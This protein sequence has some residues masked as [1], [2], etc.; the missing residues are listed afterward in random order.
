MS[1]GVW[2]GWGRV[3]WGGVS[4]SGLLGPAQPSHFLPSL[5]VCA[6][7]FLLRNQ[8]P[9]HPLSSQALRNLSVTHSCFQH[10]PVS[11][12]SLCPCS[13]PSQ[14][15]PLQNLWPAPGCC[16]PSDPHCGPRAFPRSSHAQ[17]GAP[18]GG[19]RWLDALSLVSGTR[20]LTEN[21]FQL[22]ALYLI[23][24]PPPVFPVLGSPPC[25]RWHP[26]PWPGSSCPRRGPSPCQSLPGMC[27][28]GS[29]MFNKHLLC[30]STSRAQGDREG[31]WSRTWVR[32]LEPAPHSPRQ[33]NPSES[34]PWV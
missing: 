31:G 5:Q 25:A 10:I 34:V 21:Q 7:G 24:G 23:S 17:G 20:V 8:H 33:V 30:A 16:P 13:H 4:L 3:G 12:F 6:R 19:V 2:A 11:A 9:L 14:A 26:P 27:F 29:P 18:P 28:P 32:V 1:R 15:L 22:V